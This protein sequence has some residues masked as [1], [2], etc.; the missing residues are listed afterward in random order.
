MCPN[1][2]MTLGKSSCEV[3]KVA[4]RLCRLINA[5]S[6]CPLLAHHGFLVR[7]YA[8]RPRLE[9]FSAHIA[10]Q[11]HPTTNCELN[12]KEWHEARHVRRNMN[13]RCP[14]T[15][16]VPRSPAPKSLKP[17][18]AQPRAEVAEISLCAPEIV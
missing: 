2:S 17:A 11:P 7:T 18:C 3:G 8:I 5:N 13:F 16:P 1:E 14:S 6:F 12:H 10:S 4:D 9:S 15:M